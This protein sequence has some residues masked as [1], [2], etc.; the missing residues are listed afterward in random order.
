MDIFGENMAVVTANNFNFSAV[1]PEKLG[2]SE[3]T[4][5]TFAQDLSSS[6]SGFE[7]ALLSLKVTV[8]EA[9]R[10]NPRI[11]NLM[12]RNITFNSQVEEEHG[13]AELTNIDPSAYSRPT[14]GGRTLLYDAVLNAVEATNVYASQLSAQDFF[15]NG[16]VIVGT[17]GEDFGSTTA[18][19][20]IKRAIER[21]VKS[22]ALESLMVIL[23]GINAA[24]CRASLM[25]F[26]D[27]AGLTQ[28]EE[29]SSLSPSNL[30]KLAKFCSQSISSQSQSLGTGGP[31]QPITF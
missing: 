20:E 10:K 27:E 3:Y 25:R 11:D 7:D 15:V 1:K 30:A 24:S 12:L 29:V 23:V 28:F 22:E 6:L 9:C 26:K 14:C 21:G 19:A 31:S 13:F 5:V 17:D 16:I 18:P 4:L 2:A 8:V